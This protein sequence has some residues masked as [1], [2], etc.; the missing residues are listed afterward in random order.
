MSDEN[1]TIKKEHDGEVFN[2]YEES[3]DDSTIQIVSRKKK[4]TSSSTRRKPPTT[5]YSNVVHKRAHIEPEPSLDGSDFDEPPPVS[6]T[7]KPSY[8]NGNAGPKTAL[9]DDLFE[10]F[11]NP[12]KKRMNVEESDQYENESDQQDDFNPRDHGHHH[13]QHQRGYQNGGGYQGQCDDA[14]ECGGGGYDDDPSE[15]PSPG[16]NTIDEEKQDYLYKFYRLQSKGV[17]ITKKFNMSSNV[18]EMRSEFN[19]I[20]RDSDVNASIRFSRRMLMACVTGLEFLNK[21]Y[22]PFDVKLEG[23][24]ESVMENVDDYDNVFER[25]HDKYASRV[26]MAPELE[27]MLSLVGS[28]F[29]FHLTNN[30]FSGMPNIKD[31]A[32]QN[33]E[34]LK[35][36]MQTMSA[37]VANSQ[38]QHKHKHK[39][40][41]VNSNKSPPSNTPTSNAK[42]EGVEF[43]EMNPPMFDMS[44]FMNMMQ[45]GGGT[46]SSNPPGMFAPVGNYP[47]ASRTSDVGNNTPPTLFDKQSPIEMF[48]SGMESPSLVSSSSESNGGCSVTQSDNNHAKTISF[49]ETTTVGGSKTRRN[50]RNKIRSTS[51]NTISI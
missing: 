32:K 47:I 4:N 16:F 37:A 23:W 49:S 34:I 41:N 6:S 40:D 21:R 42:Q 44:S 29:M 3:S 19:R 5:T 14:S 22:D 43:R 27:L 35:N 1:I 9:N 25:L 7:K 38:P 30:M 26:S 12:D 50:N 8:N 13:H 11:T 17:P 33:P 28:A 45:P 51:A 20:Q 24:S 18:V 10:V 48:T 2:L 36:M 15:H 46:S 39:H 31:I